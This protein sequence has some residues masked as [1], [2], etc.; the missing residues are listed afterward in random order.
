M[1]ALINNNI[2]AVIGCVSA[3]II[4]VIIQ[5]FIKRTLEYRQYGYFRDIVLA[6]AWLILALWFGNNESRVVVCGA[7]LACFAGIAES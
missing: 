5:F 6:G 1:N 2:Y 4:C 3:S 7:M